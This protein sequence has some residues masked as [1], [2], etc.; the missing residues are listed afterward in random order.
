MRSLREEKIV[1]FRSSLVEI[2]D[3]VRLQ[4]HAQ[5]DPDYLYLDSNVL[6]PGALAAI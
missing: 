3:P 1:S 6:E 4:R 2:H 5:F